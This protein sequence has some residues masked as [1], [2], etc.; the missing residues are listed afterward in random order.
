MDALEDQ[1][2]HQVIGKR[3]VMNKEER[4]RLE[5]CNAW[6]EID[7]LIMKVK[8]QQKTADRE[9]LEL[10][11]RLPRMLLGLAMGNVSRGEVK[12]LK[13]RMAEL[14]EILDDAPILLQELEKEKRRRCFKPL[15]D[16][17]TISRERERYNCLKERLLDAYEPERADEL[18]RYAVELGELQDCEEFLSRFLP[19][20]SF[21][22]Q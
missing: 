8:A 5:A 15:Q 1:V 12:A 18:R 3:A 9:L 21:R 14:R 2:D 17:C 7:K 11:Q 10:D 22:K 16:A 20:H 6:V 4:I 19:E 13:N